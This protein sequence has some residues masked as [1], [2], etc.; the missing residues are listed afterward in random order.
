M[1]R[2][3]LAG[4]MAGLLILPIVALADKDSISAFKAESL[5]RA[6]ALK[7]KVKTPFTGEVVFRIL[8]SDTF[9]EGPYEEIVSVPYD[10]RK[11]KYEYL[12]KSLGAESNYYYKLVVEGADETYGPAQARPFFS[13]PA[14]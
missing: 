9:A 14:T 8:R 10:K 6:V 2:Y 12:D 13:P 3:L 4:I 11:R 1:M 7:W 5:Y